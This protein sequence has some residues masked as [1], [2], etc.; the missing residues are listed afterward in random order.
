MANSSNLTRLKEGAVKTPYESPRFSVYGDIRELT[1]M[2]GNAGMV[3]GG[4]G[5]AQRSRP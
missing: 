3:D 4:S 2:V 5:M 1:Q